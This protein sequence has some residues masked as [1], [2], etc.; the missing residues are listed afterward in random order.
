[1]A[2][3][4]V[5]TEP[6]W[7]RLPEERPRQIL[8]AALEVFGEHGLAN[9]RLEDIAKRAG[10]SKGTIYL[11]FP[12]KEEL[13]REMVRQL[14]V[15][16]LE[17]GERQFG[18]GAGNATEALTRFSRTYWQFIRS[19]QFAPLFRLIHA[20]IRNFPDLARFYADEVISRGHKLVASIIARGTQTGE[21]RDVDPSVAA[22]MLMAPFVMHG[23]WCGHRECFSP[24]AA[25]DD[26]Q[27][28]DEL[29]E[30]YLYAIRPHGATKTAVRRS[31]NTR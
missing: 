20:E 2:A 22:R 24:V 4:P 10:L 21:F 3:Q 12:N 11:Y 5:T 16:Q 8:A 28:F 7:R 23:V 31:T 9:A 13:F 14:I 19:A 18:S 1:M 15:T 6:R 27:V 17:E 26:E 25:K 30:F 29:M